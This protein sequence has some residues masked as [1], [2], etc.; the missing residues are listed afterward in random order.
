MTITG[1]TV[2]DVLGNLPTSVA[3]SHTVR[4][5]IS[6]P[7]SLS[8]QTTYTVS[9]TPPPFPPSS[10]DLI[11]GVAQLTGLSGKATAVSGAGYTDYTF[12]G[13]RDPDAAEPGQPEPSRL[14]RHQPR[15][16]H[17]RQP[18][19]AADQGRVRRDRRRRRLGSHGLRRRLSQDQ[20]DLIRLRQGCRPPQRGRRR[21]DPQHRPGALHGQ[22]HG[23]RRHG[24]FQRHPLPGH[25]PCALL[26]ALRH[27]LL[28]P[29]RP[30]RRVG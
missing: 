23:P 26:H 4:V 18:E 13:K 7:V 10:L 9:S 28:D 27:D 5:E 8:S 3:G 17:V 24:D 19:P 22:G 11:K 2:F 20:E 12:T 14:H 29:R 30:G 25:G 21:G 1:N 6:S 16:A 15:G